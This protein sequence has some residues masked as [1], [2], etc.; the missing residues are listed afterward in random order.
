MIRGGPSE[1]CCVHRA[2]RTEP[3]PH[4]HIL[5]G[6]TT[7]K[8]ALFLIALLSLAAIPAAAEAPAFTILLEDGTTVLA[9]RV[10]PWAQNHVRAVLRDGSDQ[11]ILTTEIK[12][13]KDESGHDW[14]N[15]VLRDGK[16]TGEAHRPPAA[17][18]E[19]HGFCF[20]PQPLPNC[21][22]YFVYQLGIS[23]G[24][25]NSHNYSNPEDGTML[26]LELGYMR[27]LSTKNAIG[28]GI[29][30]MAGDQVSKLAV[31]GRYRRWL[32]HSVGL[33]GA[34]GLT[35]A[36]GEEYGYYAILPG[37]IGSVGVQAGGLVGVT[38]EAEQT[39]Y[40]DG[41]E[42]PSEGQVRLRGE[43]GTGLGVAGTVV[44][45][46]LGIAVVASGGVGFE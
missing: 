42:S 28:L 32:S 15:E 4:D 24:L 38:L 12:S 2:R 17:P 39:R 22:A 1:A 10:E 27:N 21:R 5:I 35:V 11:L 34:L 13:I 41:S 14:T 31:R 36:A 29:I 25:N 46:I 30:G 7:G 8:V 16:S 33:D 9:S 18:E 19:T 40:R 43:L 23:T 20:R 44:L 26:S 45:V 6:G 3:Y 37:I